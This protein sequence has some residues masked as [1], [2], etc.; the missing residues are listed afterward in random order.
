MRNKQDEVVGS[1]MSTSS[2]DERWKMGFG[3]EERME[4]EEEEVGCGGFL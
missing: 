4:E 2:T 1:N 3:D